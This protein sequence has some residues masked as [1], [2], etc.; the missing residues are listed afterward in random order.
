MDF[1]ESLLHHIEMRPETY[2]HLVYSMFLAD[3]LGYVRVLPIKIDGNSGAEG[4]VV[5]DEETGRAWIIA[6]IFV[7]I[8]A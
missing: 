8:R 1:S 2:K 5:I 4:L 7:R 6:V 3:N